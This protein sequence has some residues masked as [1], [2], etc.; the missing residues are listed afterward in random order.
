MSM[1]SEL[2]ISSL[3][4]DARQ[5]VLTRAATTLSQGTDGVTQAQARL[6]AVQRRA[7]EASDSMASQSATLQTQIGTL[8]NVDPAEAA[9]RVSRLTTQLETSYALTARLSKLSLVN[10]L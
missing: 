6:G 9:M 5:S 2:G 10:Y 4:V 7:S 1:L 8:E 3:S